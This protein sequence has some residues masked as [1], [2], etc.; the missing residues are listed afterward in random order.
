VIVYEP[1]APSPWRAWFA[2]RPVPLS[3]LRGPYFHETG[4]WAWLRWIRR[5]DVIYPIYAELP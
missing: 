3:E 4:R 2:W 5:A 1:P